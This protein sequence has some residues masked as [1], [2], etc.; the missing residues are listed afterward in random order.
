MPTRGLAPLRGAVRTN[1]FSGGLRGL[2]PPATFLQPFG[3]RS[4]SL[5]FQPGEISAYR[6]RTV[7]PLGSL[8]GFNINAP[9][10]LD[11]KA[12]LDLARVRPFGVEITHGRI[13][14]P[15]VE[16]MRRSADCDGECYVCRWSEP[17]FAISLDQKIP[18]TLCT[19]L[20]AVRCNVADSDAGAV[21]V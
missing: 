20:K 10:N 15:A 12:A 8:S 17:P 9:H 16:F 18:A 5:L 13:C 21:L 1:D 3:L 7:R 4:S 2:R 11:N 6:Q 19:E 14:R